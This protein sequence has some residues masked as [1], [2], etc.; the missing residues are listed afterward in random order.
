MEKSIKLSRKSSF[1]EP[2]I[3][4]TLE[5]NTSKQSFDFAI[6][7]IGKIKDPVERLTVFNQFMEIIYVKASQ[8]ETTQELA[9][10]IAKRDV[11]EPLADFLKTFGKTWKEIEQ[12]I[13]GPNIVLALDALTY[14]RSE[15][16]YEALKD[17]VLGMSP[18]KRVELIKSLDKIFQKEHFIKPE[19]VDKY[20]FTPAEIAEILSSY[21]YDSRKLEYLSKYFDSTAQRLGK[22]QI[23]Q[24]VHSL[25]KDS[26]K[27][28]FLKPQ[29]VNFYGLTNVDC[30]DIINSFE[31]DKTKLEALQRYYL[32]NL[33]A[34]NLD[35]D[36]SG[37]IDF[38]PEQI[39][40][41]ITHLDDD[42]NKLRFLDIDVIQRFFPKNSEKEHRAI[43]TKIACSLQEDKNKLKILTPEKANELHLANFNVA[44]ITTTLEQDK[45]KQR[46]M[47]MSDGTSKHP[48][49]LNSKNFARIVS[50]FQSDK[51][52]IAYLDSL[53]HDENHRR[54]KAKIVSS[55]KDVPSIQ[56]YLKDPDISPYKNAILLGMFS[57]KKTVSRAD[58]DTLCTMAGI[59][60]QEMHSLSI[61][62]LPNKMTIGVE[63]ETVGLNAQGNANTDLFRD[64]R[65]VFGGFDAKRDTSLSGFDGYGGVEIISPIL[66]NHN[67]ENLNLVARLMQMNDLGANETCGAHVHI[68]ADYLDSIEAWK[69]LCEI[70]G[71]NEDL[72]YQITNQQGDALRGGVKEYARPIST[73]IAEALKKGS[74]DLQSEQDL[75][76]FVGEIKNLQYGAHSEFNHIIADHPEIDPSEQGYHKYYGL[77]FN[78]IN[79]V[80][81]NTIE[82]RLPNGTIDPQTLMDNIRLFS[83]IVS[84]SKELG[85][86]ELAIANNI[87]LSSKQ[88][89]MILAKKA[90]V[91]DK[92]KNNPNVRLNALMDLLF[93]KDKKSKQIYISRYKSFPKQSIEGIKFGKFDYRPIPSQFVVDY[94][95][96]LTTTVDAKEDFPNMDELD[97]R[98]I[99][100][101]SLPNNIQEFLRNVTMQQP[102]QELPESR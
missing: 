81:K 44:L 100:D 14:S 56:R 96:Q 10:V 37:K 95:D 16:K 7:Q 28:L 87:P 30:T 24:V 102:L 57:D 38:T 52:K 51:D 90:L 86:I 25:E 6:S 78:N 3:N 2:I 39:C 17:N 88:Q 29:N 84:V 11:S 82:F 71:N 42:K 76:K 65:K 79:S 32:Q 77:N 18:E 89:R 40:D 31:T 48:L 83:S 26:N 35:K 101:N 60:P 33:E 45:N 98:Q 70:W 9:D 19:N 34:P 55:L 64:F 4:R 36:D 1:L 91:S 43:A 27:F 50:S 47:D 54:E 75:D 99:Y 69:N 58:F 20:A 22:K 67:L 23:L 41:I 21:Q 61:P 93:D 66:Q 97:L 74:I 59:D 53:P 12:A 62:L 46:I 68:G 15:I 49:K 92:A 80:N 73:K 94:R 8:G 5:E 13:P 85:D 72:M 63:L